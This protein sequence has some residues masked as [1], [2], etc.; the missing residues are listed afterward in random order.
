M[1][2]T[3]TNSAAFLFILLITVLSE[4]MV[5]QPTIQ[6]Q[7]AYGGT[8]RDAA[9]S[10][11]PTA[12]GGYIMIGSS[13]SSNGN[14]TGNHGGNDYWLVKTD[15]TGNLQ[16]EKSYGGTGDDRGYCVVQTQDGGY[17]LVGMSSSVNGDVTGNH[18]TY[19]VWVVK[20]DGG[21]AIQWEQSYGGTG[22]DWGTFVVQ[23][24]DGN[25]LIYGVTTS[26]DGD[27]SGNHGS[28]DEWLLK[29]SSTGVIQWQKC[30]GGS[31]SE[32][33]PAYDQG[34]KAIYVAG[35]GGYFITGCSSSNDGD[36]TGHHPGG[37]P[38]GLDQ[39]V[40][41]FKTD[42]LG[43]MQWEKSFG[44]T[45][46]DKA[47]S[48]LQTTDGG[49][50][51]SG[52]STSNDG[53]V[54]GH[55]G[56][57]GFVGLS[58]VQPSTNTWVVKMDAT[59]TLQW[60][61][62]LAVGFGYCIAPTSDGGYAVGQTG[63]MIKLDA[64]GNIQW[65][66]HTNP[67]TLNP[68]LAETVS[69]VFQT[70]DQGYILGEYTLA[71]GQGD[72]VLTKL[73]PVPVNVIT[74]CVFEDLNHNCIK[75]SNEI[76]LVGKVIQALPGNYYATTDSN[77]IYTLFVDSGA[78]TVSQIASQYYTQSCPVAGTY[79]VTI[80][81]LTPNSYHND[82]GDTLNKHCADLKIGLGSSYFRACFKNVFAVSYANTGDVT[83]NNVTV[84][85]SFNNLIIPISSTV[86][87]TIVGNNYVFNLDSMKPWQSGTF[88]ITDSVSCASVTGL[89]NVCV[90]ATIHSSTMECDT[91]NNTALDCH[92]IVGS[93]DPNAKE[94][95]SQNFTS[96]G[97]VTQD[98]I[99]STDTL[100]YMIRFQNTGTFAASTVIIRDTLTDYLDASSVESETAS[101][102]YTFRIYGHGIAERTFSNINLPDSTVNE[103]GSHGFVKFRARQ[104]ANNIPGTMINNT[105]DIF[106]DYN[107]G[108]ITNTATV[109]IPLI[110][111]VVSLGVIQ[112]NK[113]WAYPNPSAGTF[114]VQSSNE[115]GPVM[116]YNSLGEL[117]SGTTSSAFM[118]TFDLSKQAAGIYILKVQGVHIRLIK[119]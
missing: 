3:A 23:K 48:G 25:Y 107:S 93:C 14:V 87:W 51:V 109:V 100:T 65:E 52:S 57:A 106:F 112:E 74:G 53:D 81:Y 46:L 47:F 15:A 83:A 104:K 12:D 17:I 113:V 32:G 63:L 89:Q 58:G 39:D 22:Q 116:I 21:G 66:E 8:A 97:Y 36:V 10:T 111:S 103:V 108:V 73:S 27:V 88:Y 117:V 71:G 42:S 62:S 9:F 118:Q 2:K 29:L 33:I 76:G 20:T 61:K 96:N 41:V 90:Q 45:G 56:L 44:G 43:T 91:T 50:I 99:V 5:A 54:T 7:H 80:S 31:G 68:A 24:G 18:G 19:D 119:E 84:T 94:V 79:G 92:Y 115:L 60:E 64:S 105:A 110:T 34:R 102:P 38:S 37:S 98:N 86:P 28:S 67:P 35:D 78:Y 77:G 114:T 72:F 59:G 49:Y 85:V 101:S 6:W 26:N 1:N 82:F 69:T 16:W 55:I 13:S 4:R 95:A 30:Y 75:D 11:A 70:S 40:W